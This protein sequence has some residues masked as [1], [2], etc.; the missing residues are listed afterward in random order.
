[1]ENF[2]Q[3]EAALTLSREWS[4]PYTTTWLELVYTSVSQSPVRGPFMVREI[5]QIAPWEKKEQFYFYNLQY[6]F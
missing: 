1:M 5:F 4:L 6:V 3:Q 2:S